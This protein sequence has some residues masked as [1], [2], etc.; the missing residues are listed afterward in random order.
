MA[1]TTGIPGL[2]HLLGGGY[3]NGVVHVYGADDAGKTQLCL[4]ALRDEA[5]MYIA[6]AGLP[7]LQDYGASA[8]VVPYT[9]EAA[10][11]A[12]YTAVA[13]GVRLVCMDSLAGIASGAEGES[14]REVD[15]SA[16]Q[17]LLF[18]GLL[19]LNNLAQRRESTILTVNEMRVDIQDHRVKPYSH[20][21]LDDVRLT[22]LSILCKRGQFVTEY[23]R[24]ARVGISLHVGRT[25]RSALKRSLELFLVPPYGV[26]VDYDEITLLTS[27]G[28]LTR[29][30]AYWRDAEGR[31]Y[32]PGYEHA[33][34][35]WRDARIG[36]NR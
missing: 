18:H 4:Q 25:W 35:R 24:L 31:T 13:S 23:G 7:E 33:A 28:T 2:D 36:S 21:V 32:G 8:V 30:G 29:T 1:I 22:V 20:R 27:L 34:R 3:P 5:G 26:D 14:L 15:A 12:A 6:C 19:E 16:T 9:S 11:E 17:R 10:I